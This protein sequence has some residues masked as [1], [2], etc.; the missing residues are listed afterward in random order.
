MRLSP[1]LSYPIKLF[2]IFVSLVEFSLCK[3]SIYLS[4]FSVQWE[5]A[6][7]NCFNP[8][9]SSSIG[10]SAGRRVEKYPCSVWKVSLPKAG[11]GMR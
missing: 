1:F 6:A 4:A 5:S 7:L 9:K 10:Y 11:V 8:S 2:S 3:P